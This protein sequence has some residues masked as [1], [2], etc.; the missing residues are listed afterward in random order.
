MLSGFAMIFLEDFSAGEEDD[1]FYCTCGD[2]G[3]DVFISMLHK[4]T[5]ISCI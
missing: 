4:M 1:F 5:E 3:G 2:R